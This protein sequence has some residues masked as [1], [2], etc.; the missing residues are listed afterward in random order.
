MNQHRGGSP[1]PGRSS[2]HSTAL[3]HRSA[4]LR[5]AYTGHPAPTVAGSR[6]GDRGSRSFPVR[7]LLILLLSLAVLALIVATTTVA[8]TGMAVLANLY[9]FLR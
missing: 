1:T 9:R 8:A 5:A 6:S 7:D 2:A 4:A 3:A